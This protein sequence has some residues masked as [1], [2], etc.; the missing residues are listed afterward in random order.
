MAWLR[1]WRKAVEKGLISAIGAGVLGLIAGALY[2]LGFR[3]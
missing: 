3:H 1:F 2:W